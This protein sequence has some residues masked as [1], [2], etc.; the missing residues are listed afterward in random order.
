MIKD[1]GLEWVILGHSERR[2][3]FGESNELIGQKTEAALKVGLNVVFCV[4]ESLEQRETD[5]TDEI[6]QAQLQPLVGKVDW[7]K[8]VIAY[9]PV[10]AIG[11][12]KVATPEQAQDT[13]NS[14]RKWL[15][16]NVS[17]EVAASTRIIYGGSVN[18]SNC[19]DLAT[20][21]DID[22]F[23]VGGASLQ[24]ESFVAIVNAKL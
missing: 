15:Q 2:S 23:L 3:I 11:T 7:S 4:G 14:I 9:E 18:A 17:E 22:G 13:H 24:V 20:R 8:I 19:K 1:L 5:K 6:V 12:G 16:E 21:P 10:W